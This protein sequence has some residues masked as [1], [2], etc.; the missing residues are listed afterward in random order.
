MR[1]QII[2][3]H[4]SANQN[5]SAAKP[6][7]TVAISIFAPKSIKI[8][9][10]IDA[11]LVIRGI[12]SQ[13]IASWKASTNMLEGQWLGL[14]FLSVSCFDYSCNLW[15]QVQS[16]YSEPAKLH[17]IA[18]RHGYDFQRLSSP[19]HSQALF[20]Q[21]LSELDKMASSEGAF[22]SGKRHPFCIYSMSHTKIAGSR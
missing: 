4:G 21:N 8:N 10:I 16:K 1:G 6:Y 7:F 9:L 2:S 13:A 15:L 5:V 22:L 11:P 19:W 3:D 18:F 12:A 20:Y 14:R 17:N